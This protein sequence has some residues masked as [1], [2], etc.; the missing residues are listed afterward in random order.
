VAGGSN[1]KSP[2]GG[3]MTDTGATALHNL[4]AEQALLGAIML[5]AIALDTVSP[6]LKAT[7]LFDPVHQ[8]I[9]EA[10]LELGQAGKVVDAVTV[11]SRFAGHTGLID[12]GGVRYLTLLVNSA[13]DPLAVQDYAT[14][15]A[16]LSQK[17]ALLGAA[18]ALRSSL[19]HGGAKSATDVI[20]EHEATLTEIG[21]A[22]GKLG[23]GWAGVLAS[24][25]L[26][27]LSKPEAEGERITFGIPELD[28]QLGGL[29]AGRLMVVGGR[30][31]MGKSAITLQI[32]LNLAE[33]G[34]GVSFFSLDMEGDDV[35]DRLLSMCSRSQRIEYND[36]ASGAAIQTWPAVL[37]QALEVMRSL[38]I[39]IDDRR[40]KTLA[41]VASTIR[42]QKI[43]MQRKGCALKVVIIDHLHKLKPERQFKST[44]EQ[45]TDQ[46][47]RIKDLAKQMDVAIILCVQL[48]RSVEIRDDKRPV[49][50]D[51]RDT[52]AIEEEAEVVALLYRE[53][54]YLDAEKPKD[55]DKL[56]AWQD[57]KAKV[58][59]RM[60]VICPK[61]RQGKR[62]TVTLFADMGVNR[63]GTLELSGMEGF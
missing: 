5:D 45:L 55:P 23:G 40:G 29:P 14:L 28:R 50:S 59:N 39:V 51:M 42:R 30:P 18:E 47:R 32:A 26:A 12:L 6:V 1:R 33:A 22:R 57:K 7:D 35:S 8:A 41:D 43:Q 58:A 25:R 53:A 2:G 34:H 52:G 11:A 20:A 54:Y 21:L 37:D 36:I 27:V 10:C 16:E 24:R 3:D 56:E 9:L 31:S 15:L 48:S 13:C 49:M 38:P 17:R 62:G 4:E 61:V 19:L 60:E 63:V 44:Y 46:V